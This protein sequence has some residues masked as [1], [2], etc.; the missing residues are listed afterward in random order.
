[1]NADALLNG[2]YIP[3]NTQSVGGI[4]GSIRTLQMGRLRKKLIRDAHSTRVIKAL[5]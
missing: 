4:S 1:M 5:E 2:V 3:G